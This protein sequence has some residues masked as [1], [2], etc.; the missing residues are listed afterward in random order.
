MK[1]AQVKE[2][3]AKTSE[4]SP[5]AGQRS[6]GGRAPTQGLLLRQVSPPPVS[7]NLKPALQTK[8][9]V[10][11][12]GDASE[13]EADRVAERVLMMEEKPCACGGS[14]ARCGG[15][16]EPLVRR[17]A[18]AGQGGQSAPDSFALGLG[19]GRPLDLRTRAFFEA[20]FNQDFG[21]VR[22]HTDAQAAD[23]ARAVNA[24]AYTLGGNVVFD[25]G[26]FSPDTAEGRRLLAHELTHVVQ[27]ADGPPRSIH[28]VTNADLS[29]TGL[30][31]ELAVVNNIIRF[32]Y[33][34]TTIPAVENPKIATQATPAARDVTLNGFTSEE[35][36]ATSR[37]NLINARIGS[38]TS[39]LATAGHTGPKRPNPQP[40]VSE[41]NRDYRSMRIVEIV[42]TPVSSSGGP[43]PPV[44]T[45]VT[46][47]ATTSTVPC[48]TTY[49]NASPIADTKISAAITALTSPNAA[50]TA[51]VAT[52]FG[53]TPAATLLTNI[54]ALQTKMTALH[55]NHSDATDCHLGDCD[56]TCGAGA[57]AY[58]NR[59]VTPHK[60]I[61]CEPFVN[62][63]VPGSRAD[64]LIHEAL[65]ATPGVL[66][67][68]IAYAHTRR[69]RTLTDA[70][71]LKNTDSYV[72]LIRIL[73]DPTAVITSPPADAVSGTANATETAFAQRA[74][75][76][77][78]QW[79]IAA[80]F[81]TGS[82]YAEINKAVPPGPDRTAWTTTRHW[83]HGTMQNLSPLFG[84]T[85]PGVLAPFA[86]PA[87]DDKVRVAGIGD[88]YLRMRTVMHG[89]PVTLTKISSGA[90]AWAANLGSSVEVTAPFFAMSDVN[91]I[92]HLVKLM[93]RTMSDVPATLINS[94]ATGVN[95]I[96]I[97]NS[98]GP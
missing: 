29:I 38:V 76:F 7:L 34:Q 51:A 41:G 35:G 97:Q 88:R 79:L 10:S 24:Q 91:A 26:R 2:P 74:I 55:G 44:P 39:A 15:G 40:A 60:M 23:S 3:A 33:N 6:A 8:L 66:T 87:R 90:D 71:K 49:S 30:A 20:R 4:T 98:V 56:G 65:H 82:L 80:K 46:N 45:S 69:I 57:A 9:A 31:P 37:T 86:P 72:N 43:P 92:K 50:T 16:K 17:K 63:P 93:L 73:H 94:Y 95:K 83:F 70:E 27:Q 32:D 59:G 84:L 53:A 28:R 25:R 75:D 36:S 21:H 67:E 42:N 89:R 96:R 1:Y 14:C 13:Q 48:G 52:H 12:P 68:D 85:N 81:T 19:P 78:E 54:T 64:T 18:D 62:N 77:L 11:S 47:C 5:R 58:V 61:L 22:V